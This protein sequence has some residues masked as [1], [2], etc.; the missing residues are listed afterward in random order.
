MKEIALANKQKSLLQ[1]QKCAAAYERELF[2]DF[3]I[4]RHF[5]SLYNSLLEENLKKIIFPYD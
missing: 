4:S 1:F 3:V 5:N 2:E